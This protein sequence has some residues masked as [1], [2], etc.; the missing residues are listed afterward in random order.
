MLPH[1]MIYTLAYQQEGGIVENFLGSDVFRNHYKD[2]D[3][4]WMVTPISSE[5]FMDLIDAYTGENQLSE[6]ERGELV[7]WLN[8]LGSNGSM[9]IGIADRE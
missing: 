2:D 4:P 1:I 8:G 6:D 9:L 3:W 7:A 5:Q